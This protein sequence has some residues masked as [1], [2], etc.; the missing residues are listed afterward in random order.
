MIMANNFSL[1]LN[2]DKE[3]YAFHENRPVVAAIPQ[4]I[5]RNAFTGD[6]DQRH[7]L[8]WIAAIKGEDKPEDCYSRLCRRRVAH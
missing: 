8:E 7:H 3:I 1:K 2:G 6:N 5:P 4:V